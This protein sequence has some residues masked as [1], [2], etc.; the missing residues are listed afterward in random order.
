MRLRKRT[1]CEDDLI[2][3]NLAHRTSDWLLYIRA[4]NT[5]REEKNRPKGKR[6]SPGT[7]YSVGSN[8][9]RKAM[10]NTR[11]GVIV[12]MATAVVVGA[13]A[14]SRAQDEADA[15]RFRF[16]SVAL[17]PTISLTNV[18]WDSNV[19]NVSEDENPQGDIT[20]TASPAVEAW[21]RTPRVRVNGRSRLDMYY[22]SSLES[23][24]AVDNDHS[25]R[26]ELFLNRVMPWVSGNFARTRHRQNLEIDAI[27]ER[28]NDAVQ[29]GALVR[30]T[31]KTSA[32]AYVERSHVQFQG[33][34]LFRGT[35]LARALNQTGLVEG[36]AIRYEATPLTTITLNVDHGRNR[37]AFVSDRDSNSVRILPAVEFKPLA[38]ISG[39]AAIG[40]RALRFRDSRQPDFRGVVANVDLQYT[41]RGRTQV[42]FAAQRDLEYSYIDAQLDYVLTWL[43]TT[44]RQRFGDRWDAEGTV[45]RYRIGYRRL[46]P[47]GPSEGFPDEIVLNTNVGV[48]YNIGE[49]TRIGFNVDHHG[50]QSDVAVGRGYDR[51]RIGS[52]LTHVF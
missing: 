45:K 47:N 38:L 17:S 37:F 13:V 30:L 48:G 9:E 12:L 51:L 32:G 29:V 49:R 22:F 23:L 8:R 1:S 18:G 3:G 20:A 2:F 26:V 31:R 24:R 36:A 14:P 4:R 52:S 6:E 34:A 11:C 42:G 41:F 39:R 19:F 15:A 7:N 33:E 35:D 10:S 43:G 50:R 44:V 27:A 16:R 25:A 46:G 40:F 5:T 21:L 28:R